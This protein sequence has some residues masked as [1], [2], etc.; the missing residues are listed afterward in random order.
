M[1]EETL[2]IAVLQW[3]E[4]KKRENYIS[5]EHVL[6]LKGSRK[7]LAIRGLY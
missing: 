2:Q 3:L 6:F 4:M 1:N 7:L 5:Q